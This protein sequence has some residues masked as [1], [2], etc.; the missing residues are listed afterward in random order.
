MKGLETGRHGTSGE[1]SLDRP[2]FLRSLIDAEGTGIEIG[3]SYNPLLPKSQGFNVEIVDYL[4]AAGLR[5]KYA[6]NP[7]VGVDAIEDVDHVLD[8]SRSLAEAIGRRSHYDYI[9]ASHVIEH[10]P[11]ML[12]FLKSCD[13]LLKEDGVLLLA[14]PDKRHCFDVLQPLSTTGSVLQAHLERR[15]IPSPGAVFDDR[16]YNAVRNGQIGWPIGGNGALS[17]FAG[18]SDAMGSFEAVRQHQAYVDVHVWRFVP[19]SFRLIM[20]DLNE[21]GE[22]ALRERSFHDS[23]GNEFYLTLSKSG[24]GCPLGRL[25]LASAAIAEQ[26]AIPV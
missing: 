3:P 24:A 14:V 1:R 13:A 12:A 26:A 18:L 11:D 9:V 21:I 16:A 17:F 22:T 15:T 25:A 20:R 10:V 19:S 4:D 8:G 2:A 23:V 5:A 6:G 7:N